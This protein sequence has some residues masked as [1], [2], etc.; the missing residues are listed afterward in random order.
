MKQKNFFFFIFLPQ[1]LNK[2]LSQTILENTD[3]TYCLKWGWIELNR[4]I[5]TSVFV[6]IARDGRKCQRKG[7]NPW[8]SS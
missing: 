8:K 2:L 1:A 7:H 3:L 6:A 5:S 4:I